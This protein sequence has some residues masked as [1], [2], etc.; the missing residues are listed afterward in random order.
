MR[1]PIHVAD[2]VEVARYRCLAGPHDR[3]FDEEH[4][5]YSISYVE[6]GVFSY[7][8]ARGRAELGPGWL[9]LGNEG[10]QYV[11]S[12]EHNDGGG[13]SCIVVSFSADALASLNDAAI[14]PLSGAFFDRVALAPVPRISAL[15][16]ALAVA[17]GEGFAREEAC[18]AAAA[19]VLTESADAPARSADADDDRAHACARFIERH[20]G[21]PLTLEA[22]AAGAGLSVFHFLRVF[23]AVIGVTPH[24]YLMRTRLV[25]AV[26][27]LRDTDLPV[28]EVAY[29]SGWND[30]STFNRTFR[31]EIGCTP[32]RL[33][34][35]K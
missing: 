6:H 11:C 1:R 33:R 19:A 26:A 25:R 15:F 23:R 29:E 20:A 13:D 17:D 22:L 4:P 9:M 21:E 8:S 2:G 28:T 27:M 31:R 3:P 16:A 18:L 7:R 5:A 32:R 24:Q 10:E 30:L 12:H 14:A 35:A 34:A